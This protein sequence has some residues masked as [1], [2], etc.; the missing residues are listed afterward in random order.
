MRGAVLTVPQFTERR[1]SEPAF[2]ADG[3]RIAYITDPT[4][5]EIKT[6]L[7]A[8]ILTKLDWS[9]DGNAPA[10]TGASGWGYEL[11]LMEGFLHSVERDN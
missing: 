6:G 1:A 5:V 2:S 8:A 3:T 9:P 4:P 10:F 11:Y 7:K